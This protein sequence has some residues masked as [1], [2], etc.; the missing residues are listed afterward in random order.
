MTY[1]LFQALNFGK[2]SLL[3]DATSETKFYDSDQNTLPT[4]SLLIQPDLAKTLRLIS[5][6][7]KDGFY[8]GKI[9]E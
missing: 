8:K 1:D 6:K 7:G 2:V 4:D 5:T 9:A 3:E